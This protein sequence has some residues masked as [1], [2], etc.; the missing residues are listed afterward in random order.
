MNPN[1]KAI[2]KTYLEPLAG[3]LSPS[4]DPD[5]YPL[6]AAR[7]SS[8]SSATPSVCAFGLDTSI[9]INVLTPAVINTGDYLFLTDALTF[10]FQGNN[11][12]YRATL[13]DPEGNYVIK[14]NND[15]LVVEVGLCL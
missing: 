10:P 12:Y 7:I 11:Q 13:L 1:K 2:F 6:V 5:D 15:G 8:N 4:D 3:G 14:V 9:Y